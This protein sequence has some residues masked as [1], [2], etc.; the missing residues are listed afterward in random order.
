MK[1]PTLSDITGGIPSRFFLR[2]LSTIIFIVFV[3]FFYISSRFDCD[4]ARRSIVNL[5]SKL[6]VVRTDVQ[7]ERAKYMSSTCESKMQEMVD[8]LKLGLRIQ[9]QPPY[10][11]TINK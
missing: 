11:L 1:R 6:E 3:A 9:D 4:T 7:R 5:N 10:K 8:S 2:H